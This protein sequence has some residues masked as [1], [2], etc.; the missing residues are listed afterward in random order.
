MAH[1]RGQNSG[2]SMAPM[3]TENLFLRAKNLSNI[4]NDS[5]RTIQ[6]QSALSLLIKLEA[7]TEVISLN[8]LLKSVDH[9]TPC[10]PFLTFP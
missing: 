6:V 3:G 1:S 2:T 10:L 7:G 9:K 4:A 5:E 8:W